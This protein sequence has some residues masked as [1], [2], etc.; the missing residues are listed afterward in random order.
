MGEGITSNEGERRAGRGRIRRVHRNWIRP[1][2]IGVIATVLGGL[3]L[4]GIILLVTRHGES[5]AE[6]AAKEAATSARVLQ[7][8]EGFEGR[9]ATHGGTFGTSQV[10]FTPGDRV[11]L[12]VRLHNQ[13]SRNLEKVQVWPDFVGGGVIFAIVGI[14]FSA[15]DGVQYDSTK[16]AAYVSFSEAA[17]NPNYTVGMGTLD[18]ASFRLLDEH[19]HLVRRIP[20]SNGTIN[21]GTLKKKQTYYVEFAVDT[22]K[23]RREPGQLT[24]GPLV[25]VRDAAAPASTYSES[26]FVAQ[27]GER[28]VVSVEI[29]N[30]SYTAVLAP[31]LRVTVDKHAGYARLVARI[32][33]TGINSGVPVR[34]YPLTINYAGDQ[35][36][37]LRYIP[38]STRAVA[39]HLRRPCGSADYSRRRLPDGVLQGGIEPAPAIGVDSRRRPEAGLMFVDFD[40]EVSRR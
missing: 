30:S 38:G 4:A 1:V 34:S 14:G 32:T 18:T 33:P 24:G 11:V 8:V 3:V 13:S 40:L 37:T 16:D 10:P 21:V 31:T 25:A 36:L 2:L 20:P 17:F 23:G 22:S 19:L 15:F 12:R 27:P 9:D 7:S 35:R 26:Y 29:H 28:L 39:C 6:A 5:A